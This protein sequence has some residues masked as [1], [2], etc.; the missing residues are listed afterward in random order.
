MDFVTALMAQ[1]NLLVVTEKN[2]VK[3]AKHTVAMQKL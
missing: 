1:Q 2:A 3:I